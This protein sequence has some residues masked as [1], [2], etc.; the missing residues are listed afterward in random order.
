MEPYIENHRKLLWLGIIFGIVAVMLI[1]G[2]TFA[3]SAGGGQDLSFSAPKDAAEE[4]AQAAA[5]VA[6]WTPERM[7]SA[8]PYPMPRRYVDPNQTQPAAASLPPG[9]PG[10]MPGYNPKDPKSTPKN[11]PVTLDFSADTARSRS[12]EVAVNFTP[13]S[14]GY[15][16]ANT[17]MQWQPRYRAY[18]MSTVGKLLFQQGTGSWQCSASLIGYGH[19]V[20][21]GHC[22]N[23]GTGSG[24]W[25][26]NVMFCPSWDSSQGGANPAVGCWSV[27]DLQSN[28]N[29][30]Y[31]AD[32]DADI[33]FGRTVQAGT[34][35]NDYPGNAVG[36]LGYAWNWGIG[37]NDFM[38]GY[39]CQD[40]V[41]DS[42]GNWPLHFQCGK[43]IVTLAEEAGYTINWG[44]YPDSKFIGTTQ[45]P[46]CSG[47]PW[48]LGWGY[49][50]YST[51]DVN[52]V[53]GVNSHLRCCDVDCTQLY[54]EV[55]SPQFTWSGDTTGVCVGSYTSNCGAV[56][57]IYRGFLNF[58]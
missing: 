7:R 5:T 37:Q 43:I 9:P 25:S 56:D 55:S 16:S 13:A 38:V 17:T 46:G 18:P 32:A 40:R 47:G 35:I 8:Q 28:V 12:A 34:V 29:W 36:W 10:G 22:V 44:L 52:Y 49:Q 42:C 48:V 14:A 45:T 26:Y 41:S 31:H 1:P 51:W 2:M 11:T 57:T 50:D 54:R 19:I 53:N 3:Q 21:A 20:T 24:S 6:F 39:P 27:P 30:I 23:G 15:P 4:A 33:G 58:P